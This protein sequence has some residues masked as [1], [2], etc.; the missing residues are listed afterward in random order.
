MKSSLRL[1]ATGKRSRLEIGAKKRRK[2]ESKQK[3]FCGSTFSYI[4]G[5]SV[6][7]Y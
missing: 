4:Y 3:E 6:G 2:D 7:A 1:E 5:K